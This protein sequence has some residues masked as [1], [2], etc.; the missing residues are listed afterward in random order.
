MARHGPSI[1][2][3]AEQHLGDRVRARRIEMGL[4]QVRLSEVAGVNQGYLSAIE[5][6]RRK[7]SART[8]HALAV[9]LDVPQAVLIGEGLAH[10]N[11]QPVEIRHL[12]TFGSIPA[13]PPGKSQEQMELFP[14]LKHLWSPDFYCLRLTFDSMEPTLK[15]G[16]MVLVH[17]RPE[18][19]P[20]LVQGKI[21][22]CLVDGEPTLKRVSVDV[23]SGK[24]TII[25]RGDN[26]SAKPIVIDES[27]DFSI[28][29][30][31]T[32]LVSRDL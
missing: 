3:R 2:D 12:P 9:A 7:P 20:E 17:Y 27:R 16:D 11:P 28:Q 5:R 21:C 19:Q 31:V 24:R 14:V 22:A 26:P 15:P 4:S 1:T 32:S 29:G 25:L 30:I 18:V 23:S 6:D 13:G 8:L 10:D